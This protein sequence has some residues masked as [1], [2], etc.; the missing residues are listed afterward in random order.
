[1]NARVRIA[2]RRNP[3]I[4]TNHMRRNVMR[5]SVVTRTPAGRDW[6][7]HRSAPF[8]RI[9]RLFLLLVVWASLAPSAAAQQFLWGAAT[10]SY[11]VEGG[12]KCSDSSLPC[13]DYDFFNADPAI[14]LRVA[15]NSSNTGPAFQLAPADI[16]DND[17]D[18]ATYKRDFDNARLL[19]M[20]ALRIS[21]E[22]GRIEPTK[23]TR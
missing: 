8:M 3:T 20:N 19:G 5:T 17:W 14:A 11:Q 9:G 23:P 13:N 18:P 12:I 16:A 22:W 6:R 7:S 10:S 4:S 2:A 21:L 1:M 15:I